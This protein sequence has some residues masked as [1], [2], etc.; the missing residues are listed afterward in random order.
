MK[1]LVKKTLWKVLY[2]IDSKMLVY[3][4]PMP[5][6]KAFYNQRKRWSAGGKEVGLYGKSLMFISV[7]VHM[8]IP[9]SFFVFDLRFSFLALIIVLLADFGLLC[10]TTGLVQRRDLLKYFLL[11]EG[12]YFFYT[13]LFTPVLLFPTTV[14]WKNISYSWKFNWKLKKMSG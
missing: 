6:V 3:S 7:M 1:T 8:L 13:I 2:P 12:F 4:Q 11:W 9:I 14:K 5:D 10:R